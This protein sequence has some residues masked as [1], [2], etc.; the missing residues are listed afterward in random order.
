MVI[1]MAASWSEE[2]SKKFAYIYIFLNPHEGTH[3]VQTCVKGQLYQENMRTL[4]QRQ[5]PVITHNKT[6]IQ[7]NV[8]YW[9]PKT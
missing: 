7:N 3:T 5:R 2:I 1:N 8:W 4:T 9:F 6:G